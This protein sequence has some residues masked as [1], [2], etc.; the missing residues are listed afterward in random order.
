MCRWILRTQIPV[1]KVFFI[2]IKKYTALFW[3]RGVLRCLDF[4]FYS[5]VD[6][7]RLFIVRSQSYSYHQMFSFFSSYYGHLR[8]TKHTVIMTARSESH[9]I[10]HYTIYMYVVFLFRPNLTLRQSRHP[11]PRS[12][13]VAEPR[14]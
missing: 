3:Y 11:R 12:Q 8:G 10:S 14:P 13:P 1:N 9:Q 4:S 5:F 6:S 2:V 7:L